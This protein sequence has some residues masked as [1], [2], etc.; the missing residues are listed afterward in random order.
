M[1]TCGMISQRT[2]IFY[3]INFLSNSDAV[4]TDYGNKTFEKSTSAPTDSKPS[5]RSFGGNH[6][7]T[8]IPARWNGGYTIRHM[9]VNFIADGN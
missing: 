8:A 7:V 2:G 5:Y 1:L 6:F 3:K 9:N 4:I